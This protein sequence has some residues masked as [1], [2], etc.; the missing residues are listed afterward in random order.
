MNVSPGLL[1]YSA[2]GPFGRVL[3]LVVDQQRRRLTHLVVKPQRLPT[4]YG[5]VARLLPFEL[6]GTAED[7]MLLMR[8]SEATFANLP[9]LSGPEHST[10]TAVNGSEGALG[11]MVLI[12]AGT[13][14]IL[15]NGRVGKFSQ[16]AV[17][18]ADG[19][20]EQVAF[21]FGHAW[22]RQQ[23]WVPASAIERIEGDAIVLK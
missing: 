3:D 9:G 1:V 7:G 11:T 2:S 18:A 6:L 15:D 13:P 4:A 23:S 16:L 20:I 5:L 21:Y 22:E 17:R 8:C 10:A 12:G 19:Q 14:V